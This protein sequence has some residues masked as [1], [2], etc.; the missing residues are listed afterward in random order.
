MVKKLLYLFVRRLKQ[1]HEDA[2]ALVNHEGVI[3]GVYSEVE[4]T[5]GYFFILS[6]ANLIA[7]T[8]L[9]V[10]SAP[11]IIGA[12]LISPLMGPILSTGFAFATGNKT[13]WRKALKKVSLSIALT[14]LVAAAAS[15]LSPLQDLTT[16][17]LARSR[18]NLYDLLI[19]IFAGLAGAGAICTKKNYITVVPGVA[20]ATAVIPPL[21]V[22]GFGIGTGSFRIMAGGFFL[23][24]TNFVAIIIATCA[25]LFFFGFKPSTDSGLD[26]AALKKRVAFLAS[27]LC[28]ICV[29]LIYT[30][31]ESVSELGLKKKIAVA[32]KSQFDQPG[33][34]RLSA[35]S[36]LEKADKSIDISA[37][38]NTT[39]YLSEKEIYRS[40]QSIRKALRQR[41]VFHLEQIKVQPGGLK[42]EPA[43]KPFIAPLPV[44][45]RQPVEIV[46]DARKELLQL[47][48]S[49]TERIDGIIS[50][51]VVKEF[52][53]GIPSND[54]QISLSLVIMRDYPLSADE[55][56]FLERMTASELGVPVRLHVE[57]EPFISP[58]VFP[59][60]DVTI[61][62]EM[63]RCLLTAKQ[64]FERDSDMTITVASHP[65]NPA[66]RNSNRLAAK[67]RAKSVALFLRETCGI[68]KE[69][70]RTVML[71]TGK[72]DRPTVKVSILPPGVG[73]VRQ[74]EGSSLS[75]I[76]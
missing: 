72:D 24:F 13:I 19:A 16:E 26:K 34:S 31:H 30:L 25:V 76:R 28:F 56:R 44:R 54:A 21:S 58:M 18:P 61:S 8:G 47:I 23:F 42:D 45:Q 9:I 37:V 43:V 5:P 48:Q 29:P 11:V 20:I 65:E 50:P 49:A 69:R 32:L 73:F 6:L 7:L 74:V 27:V 38:I 53:V 55:L 75:G 17:I 51:S 39:R 63:E 57:T 12:M 52:I 35:F 59:K 4:I 40:E 70:I 71:P 62:E 33:V 68:P 64:V 10:N 41:L 3:N 14:L 15:Y 66:K 2:V 22:A 60:G 46:T 1:K 67:A 36:H